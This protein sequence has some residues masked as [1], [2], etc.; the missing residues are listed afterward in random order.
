MVASRLS[1][2]LEIIGDVLVIGLAS[3]INHPKKTIRH[4]G[5]KISTALLDIKKL[6]IMPS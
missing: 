4:E 6:S 5:Y 1:R 2:V 3:I